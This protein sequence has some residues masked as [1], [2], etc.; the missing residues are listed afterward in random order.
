M[1][2]IEKVPKGRTLGAL[3][4]AIGLIIWLFVELRY[5]SQMA[6]RS[7]GSSDRKTRPPQYSRLGNGGV[8]EGSGTAS[9]MGGGGSMNWGPGRETAG[10][11]REDFSFDMSRV[12]SPGYIPDD[13]ELLYNPEWSEHTAFE[14][15]PPER[16][17]RSLIRPSACC[18]STS[19]RRCANRG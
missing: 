10:D 4:F 6:D 11:M 7:T 5:Q 1:N 14:R 19:S 17:L 16:L 8:S 15:L 12:D 2:K 9:A 3:A 18:T 13:F